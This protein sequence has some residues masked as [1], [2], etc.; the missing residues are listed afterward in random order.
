MPIYRANELVIDI[1]DG[2]ADQTIVAFRIPAPTGGREA[3]LV[4]TRDPGLGMRPFAPYVAEQ[5]AQCR[6]SLPRFSL[7]KS[8]PM[9]VHG[10]EA[11]WLEFTWKN[12]G[13]TMLLRQIYFNCAP[14]AII[15]TL[16]VRPD[17]MAY[18]EP[19]WR[20]TMASLEFDRLMPDQTPAFPPR[21]P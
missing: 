9:D 14:L 16:T 2:W 5:E 8:D 21:K 10:R 15:C 20:R 13:N 19:A 4:I 18:C 11:A 3:S 12:E 6:K 1:P 17:D 7:I